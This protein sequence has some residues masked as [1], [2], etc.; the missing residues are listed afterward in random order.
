MRPRTPAA[1]DAQ[2]L[3]LRS[4]DRVEAISQRG[5]VS[6]VELRIT[7]IVAP[8]RSFFP[9]I[10]RKPMPTRSPKAHTTPSRAS[11]T[12]SNAQSAWRSYRQAEALANIGK[13]LTTRPRLSSCIAATTVARGHPEVRAVVTAGHKPW[14]GWPIALFIQEAGGMVTDHAGK[15][16][17]AEDC[18]NRIAAANPEDHSAILRIMKGGAE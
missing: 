12:S 8:A 15:R 3:R 7:K 16:Y 17:S 4:H 2:Q 5:C 18:S 1:R 11:P 10:S 6:Q 9:F 14:D 13:A